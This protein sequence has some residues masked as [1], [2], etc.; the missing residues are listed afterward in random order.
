[1]R[2]YSNLG[3]RLAKAN[4]VSGP[5]VGLIIIVCCMMTRA[6]GFAHVD[7]VYANYYEMIF[8]LWSMLV[9]YKNGYK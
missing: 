3:K 1:M 2:T 7:T 4:Q 9:I 8:R 6:Y 5:I